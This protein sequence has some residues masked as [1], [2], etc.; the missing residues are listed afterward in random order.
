MLVKEETRRNSTMANT[1]ET[2]VYEIDHS[3]FSV[4]YALNVDYHWYAPDEENEIVFVTPAPSWAVVFWCLYHIYHGW[5]HVDTATSHDGRYLCW[6]SAQTRINACV[7]LSLLFGRQWM[8]WGG[9]LDARKLDFHRPTS[10]CRKHVSFFFLRH[11]K[12]RKWEFLEF[13]Y[14]QK[15]R[16]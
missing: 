2:L 4:F 12:V 8:Q 10:R 13:F 11:D 9:G 7:P 15:T 1:S 5:H 3:H 14:F 6:P 16:Q